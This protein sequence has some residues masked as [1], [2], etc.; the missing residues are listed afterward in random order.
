[1]MVNNDLTGK[2]FE[3]N[4]GFS[5]AMFDYRKLLLGTCSV[6]FC[7]G[8]NQFKQVQKICSINMIK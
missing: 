4:G 5:I 1:M 7:V 6:F 3:L 2:I 8:T